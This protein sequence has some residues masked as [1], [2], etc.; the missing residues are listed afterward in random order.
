MVWTVVSLSAWL[1]CLWAEVTWWSPLMYIGVFV[2]PNIIVAL[3]PHSSCFTCWYITWCVLCKRLDT[4]SLLHVCSSSCMV[5]L[6]LS[7]PQVEPGAHNALL[8][9][10]HKLLVK[11]STIACIHVRICTPVSLLPATKTWTE[12]S[13]T[14]MDSLRFLL[15]FS[16]LCI[17]Y[18]IGQLYMIARHS[19]EETRGG[20]DGVEVVVNESCHDDTHGDGQYTEK[21]IY[22][23]RWEMWYWAHVVGIW[24]YDLP[25]LYTT[26]YP[27]HT[28]MCVTQC[29]SQSSSFWAVAVPCFHSK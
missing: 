3:L 22:L 5:C 19:A 24:T 13:W 25:N 15:L 12:E 18:R 11:P 4:I 26:C 2:Q 20:G 14:W 27:V 7:N 10:A 6:L 9:G 23:T 17:Q 1:C 21:R 29:V 8:R 28:Y 16:F